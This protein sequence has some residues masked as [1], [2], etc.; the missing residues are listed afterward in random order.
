MTATEMEESEP[1]NK[2][3]KKKRKRPISGK[4]K[5]QLQSESLIIEAFILSVWLLAEGMRAVLWAGD[6]ALDGEAPPVTSTQ[7][8]STSQTMFASPHPIG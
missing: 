8:S 7:W 2:T 4:I 6:G 5:Y 3:R 1:A